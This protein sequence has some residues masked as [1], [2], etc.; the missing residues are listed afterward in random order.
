MTAGVVGLRTVAVKT[1]A[2]F[3]AAMSK[4]YFERFYGMTNAKFNRE[5]E[6]AHLGLEDA[7]EE[8]LRLPLNQ[9]FRFASKTEESP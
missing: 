8:V 7:R 4:V 9:Y 2:D 3:D 1:A 5:Y 6:T